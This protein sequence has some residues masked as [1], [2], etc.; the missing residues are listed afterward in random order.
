MS[1]MKQKECIVITGQ[2]INNAN[3]RQVSDEFIQPFLFLQDSSDFAHL[4]SLP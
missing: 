4:Q 2:F 3:L 1:R